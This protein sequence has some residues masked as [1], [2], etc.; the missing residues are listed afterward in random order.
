M[1]GA[2]SSAND[3]ITQLNAARNL[4]L[5]D[6]AY[7]PQIVP[8]VVPI[9]GANASL[10]L[11]RWGADFLAETFASPTLAGEEKQKLSLVVLQTLKDFLENPSED[12]GVVKSVVQAAASIY[13]LVVRH[14]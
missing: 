8:G 4:A 9:I 10:D 5:V 1:N 3:T 11:R 12:T 13:P 14:T 7:Y 6:A 2:G